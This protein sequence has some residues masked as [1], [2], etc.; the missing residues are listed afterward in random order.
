[1][2]PTQ[3]ADHFDMRR[4]TVDTIICRVRQVARRELERLGEGIG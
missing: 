2:T 3:V 1:M 4:G